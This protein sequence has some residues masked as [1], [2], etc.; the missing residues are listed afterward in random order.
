[1]ER[2]NFKRKVA[3]ALI[4]SLGIFLSSFYFA[5]A[6]STFQTSQGGTGTTTPSGI[7]SGDNGATGHLNTVKIGTGIT[8]DGTTLSASG[9]FPFT[10]V[11]GYNST[12]TT[13]AFLNGFF[14]TASSTQSGNFYLPALSQGFLY[15]GSNGLASTIAS[16]S[17]KLSWFN[18]DLGNYGGFLTAYDPFPTHP[19]SGVSATTSQINVVGL[20]DTASTTLTTT[21][22]LTSL[23]QGVA[24]IGSLGKVNSIASSSLN[25][26]TATALAA[27]GTNCS[28]G[29]YPLGVDASGNSENCTA[30]AVGTVTGVTG[31][32]PI[33]SS[34]GAAPNITFGGLSTTTNLTQGQLPYVTGVNTF[35]Q[36]ATT[37]LT[38]SGV[39]S[40]SNAPVVIG[41]TPAVAT[42]TGGTGGQVLAWLS[43]VPT[44]T[45][46][47]TFGSGYAT[48]TT[49]YVTHSTSTAA[50]DGV[51][52]GMNIVPTAGALTWTPTFSGNFNS[53]SHDSSL[54][55]TTY[56]ASAAVSDWGLALNH[57]NT[58]S[59]LQNFNY[60]SSTL[61]SSF[62]TASSTSLFAG[63][64]N[65]PNL[66]G[67]QCLHE[68]SGVVSGTGSDCGSGSGLSSY[69]AWTHPSAGVSATT[70]QMQF[71]GN[72]STTE[73]SINKYLLSTSTGYLDMMNWSNDKF[74]IFRI[75]A[76]LANP[77]EATLSLVDYLDGVDN[78]SNV[79]FVDFYN[80]HYSDS[81]QIGIRQ[82]YNGTGVAK[83]IVF[84]HWN[85]ALGASGKDPGNKLIL[86]PS[87]TV[88]I[89]QATSSLDKTAML[90]IASSTAAVLL[91]VDTAP[92]TTKFRVNPTAVDVYENAIVNSG[93]S[94][95]T[96]NATNNGAAYIFNNGASGLNDLTMT[97]F[98]GPQFSM[99]D[100]RFNFTG[101][102]VGIGTSTPFVSL[103]ISSTTASATFKPQLALS[104]FSAAANKKHWTLSSEGGNFYIASSTDVYATSTQ[105][106]LS[107][108][109]TG[110]MSIGTTTAGC[111]NTTSTGLLYAATCAAGGG[112]T[113][114]AT[115]N[116]LIGGTITTT[117]TIG[118]DTSGLSTN[119][120]TAWNGSKL[121]ATGTPQITF[122]NF[123]GTTTAT[124][125]LNGNLIVGANQALPYLRVAST[126]PNYGYFSN[127]LIDAYDKRNDE[128]LINAGNGASAS[129]AASGFVANGD[130]SNGGTD[131]SFF[132]FANTGWTGSNCSLN[133]L[134]GVTPE[135]T[136]VYN[137]TGN[138]DYLTGSSTTA[139]GHRWFTNGT[140]PSN[141]RMRIDGVG[142]LDLGTTTNP[143]TQMVIASSTNPQLALSAGAG[144]AQ[145]FM[146]NAGGNFYLGTTT[147]AGTATTST[148]AFSLTGSGAPQLG[149]GTSS[150]FTTLS[151]VNTAGSGF[152]L[153][154]IASSTGTGAA[155][156][157]FEID[158]NGHNI[159]S[160][161]KPTCNANCTFTAGN[162]NAFRVKLGSGVT[163]ATVTFVATWGTLAPICVANEGDAGTVDIGAS[164][165][166]TTVVLTALSSLTSKDVDVQCQGIQ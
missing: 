163:T 122:G 139:V 91:K 132:G 158:N 39:V 11:A 28:A 8:W 21:L 48:T 101:G 95:V 2:F 113:S 130:I 43:G 89:A 157:V 19:A 110:V 153:L 74:S 73:L 80:E 13:L 102:N 7:L 36:V 104:D 88:G 96:N 109:N 67:T 10:S 24:Y 34:G 5:S 86:L 119:A 112:V 138:V 9:V 25:V 6:L 144:L 134:T 165:T 85:Q 121:V 150:P 58:W 54:T 106:A 56:N 140:A 47:S 26:G 42:I 156:P 65:L 116:G 57:T 141:E 75:K 90:H 160:G 123:L 46:T 17:I 71:N 105:N 70:S 50:F 142:R 64:L 77:D 37:T 98:T 62:L 120:L 148:A 3:Y 94:L 4:A 51:T 49:N 152:P 108:T 159:F 53:H 78:S 83:P 76:P 100:T 166:P 84:G 12:S 114:V 27:N 87:G 72:A 41:G 97:A 35:G 145:W 127:D 14:S 59:V 161:P 18:N 33:L 135:D 40:I 66:T 38:G 69:D 52:F 124:S 128:M 93:N 23:S 82:A 22:N 32:W 1:M 155:L 81:Q 164:S 107:I 63:T 149:I 44:W 133:S 16:S 131:F 143:L 136:I 68:I 126:T 20:L 30:A 61:Y 151:I 79:E 146:R 60:S 99:N 137:P 15:T 129:C 103:Q 162:D 118:L 117:G 31:T 45:A 147:V 29:N 115:N 111:L 125:T 55:G 154:A 92:G